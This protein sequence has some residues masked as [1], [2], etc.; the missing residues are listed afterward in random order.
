MTQNKDWR[1]YGTTFLESIH[2][3]VPAPYT[4]QKGCVIA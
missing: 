3:M 1:K 4:L 2:K